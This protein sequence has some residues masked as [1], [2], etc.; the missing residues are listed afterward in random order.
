MHWLSVYGCISDLNVGYIGLIS[1][2]EH[3]EKNNSDPAHC[4]PKEKQFRKMGTRGVQVQAWPCMHFEV[5]IS[6]ETFGT[7]VPDPVSQR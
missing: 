3:C 5:A 7:I 4:S 6:F 2:G 1:F